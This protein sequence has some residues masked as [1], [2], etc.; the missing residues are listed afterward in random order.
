MKRRS[1]WV[2][3]LAGAV[4]LAGYA[5]LPSTPPAPDATSVAAASSSQLVPAPVPPAGD[6]TKALGTAASRTPQP[7]VYA[8]RLGYNAESFKGASLPERLMAMS[9]RRDGRVFDPQ[10][11]ADALKSDVAWQSDDSA[12]DKLPITPEERKDGREFV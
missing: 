6:Q 2:A 8:D 11:V 9:L 1:L 5:G 10:Q 3:G 4:A 7:V 12:A